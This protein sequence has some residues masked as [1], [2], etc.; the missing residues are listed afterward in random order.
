MSNLS[1][2]DLCITFSCSN[3]DKKL[4]QVVVTEK[5]D[6]VVWK[7]KARCCYCGDSSFTKTFTG[8]FSYKGD[9]VNEPTHP[10]GLRALTNVVDVA[11]ENDTIVFV[12][13]KK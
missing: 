13:E 4:V 10:D 8:H 2:E 6:Q 11:Y 3:C 12:T 9:D 7:A 1:Y 5:D